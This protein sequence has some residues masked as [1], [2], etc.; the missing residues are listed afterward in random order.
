MKLSTITLKKVV[1]DMKKQIFIILA[2][3]LLALG[4]TQNTDMTSSVTITV[5]EG[6][7]KSIA[8]SAVADAAS[9]EFILTED[10]NSANTQSVKTSDKS[11]TFNGVKIASYLVTVNGYNDENTLIET[12]SASL[13]VTVN[14]DNKTSVRLVLITGDETKGTIKLPVSW[15]EVTSVPSVSKALSAEGLRF[16]LSIN[17]SVVGS[18]TKTG[19]KSHSAD[20]VFTDVPTGTGLMASIDIY[21]AESGRLLVRNFFNAIASVYAGQT[22]V[23]DLNEQNSGILKQN[24]IVSANNVSNVS[25]I[26]PEENPDTSIRLTWV[27]P[28]KNGINQAESVTVYYSAADEVEKTLTL[29]YSSE[30]NTTEGSA[31][32][33]GLSSGTPYTI[34]FS[35]RYFNKLESEKKSLPYT[36]SPYVFVSGLT[37]DESTLPSGPVTSHSTF[38]LKTEVFP[39]NASEKSVEWTSSN[40]DVLAY[41]GGLFLAK[42]PGKA[43]LSVKT[44]G[45]TSDKT[46]ITKTIESEISVI[47]DTPVLSSEVTEN[48]IVVSW[49]SVEFAENYEVYEYVNDAEPV[50]VA[51]TGST[52]FTKNSN[53]I[54]GNSYAYSVKA[55]AA[56]YD[57]ES[58]KADSL[59]S[60][61]TAPVT[62]VKPNVEIVAPVLSEA[63]AI[64]LTP[65]SAGLLI[66]PTNTKL[67]ISVGK[68]EG[69]VSYAW[70]INGTQ[71]KSGTYSEANY[72]A[73]TKN[74]EGIYTDTSSSYNTLMLVET[75]KNGNTYSASIPF[76]VI[77]VMDTAVEVYINSSQDGVRYIPTSAGTVKLAA[78]VLPEDASNQSVTFES[79]NEDVATV[80]SNGLITIHGY[81]DVNITVAPAH[82]KATVVPF[83]FYQST[84]S[85]ALDVLNAVNAVLKGH[86]TQ[87]DKNFGGDWWP[88]ESANRYSSGN[89]EIKSSENASQSKGYIK[90]NGQEEAGLV[91][92]TTSDIELWA[93]N[94]GMAG[95]LGTDPLNYVG[96]NNNGDILVTLPYE[97]GQVSIHYS[98]I[99]VLDS[100]RGGTYTLTFQN[101][102]VGEKNYKLFADEAIT[103]S[104]LVTRLL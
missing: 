30:D 53:I 60:E 16:T 88:G 77:A 54:A 65:D 80:D 42:Q 102:A 45:L 8:P 94:R 12:G 55:T 90:I 95:Y 19:N 5:G 56:S 9:Y 69:A 7:A 15:A 3:L 89:V 22:S 46:P 31:T 23:P 104:A 29:N 41:T 103:D 92:T 49:E 13:K 87:A 63:F 70:Y 84:Y 61:K 93:K 6:N 101:V 20:L 17:G 26:M 18:L 67:T 75:D 11:A 96:N 4:C 62:I 39:A 68:S 47:L 27:N 14:G 43:A 36:V 58:F 25:S 78:V 52:S 35:V 44:E 91:L 1:F 34:S 21:D 48:S 32:L 50:K 38:A 33:T 99:D 81:G 74:T 83:K 76:E 57:T 98:N 86:I 2:V 71:I 24:M 66:T 64:T 100:N 79:S 73:I 10:G 40:K 51:D 82:G 28:Q 97:Q 59:M 85:G 72:I 37:V